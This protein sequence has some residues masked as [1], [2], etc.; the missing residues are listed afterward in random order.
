VAEPRDEELEATRIG[1]PTLHEDILLLAED[2]PEWPALFGR[3]AERIREP[4]RHERRLFK[5]P[6]TDVNVHVVRAG[7]SRSGARTGASG[8]YVQHH[9]DAKSDVVAE[10]V[11][12]AEGGS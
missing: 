11:A 7:W 9:A 5:G 3:E 4:D 8:E 2:D 10:I 1:G 6:D 12:R